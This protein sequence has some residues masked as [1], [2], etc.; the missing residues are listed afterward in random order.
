MVIRSG[1]RLRPWDQ[2]LTSTSK[3]VA[4]LSTGAAAATG[5]LTAGRP[6]VAVLIATVPVAV[7][8]VLSP[9][10]LATVLLA[11]TPF[12]IDISRGA[13]GLHAG[14]SDLLLLLAV[15]NV[16]GIALTRHGDH[17]ARAWAALRPALAWFAIYAAG[18]A[19]VLASDPSLHSGISV[20]QR[21]QLTLLPVAI[22]VTMFK[23]PAQ[24]DRALKAYLV[25]CCLL[26]VAF[27]AGSFGSTNSSILGVQKNPAGQ[28]MANALVLAIAL[29]Q[30]R[31][32]RVVAIPV[33]GL[34]MVAAASRG[35]FV[36]LAIGVALL[37]V[38]GGQVSRRR[39]LA[40][41]TVLGVLLVIVFTGL[42]GAARSRLLN[43]DSK[44]DFSIQT[45]DRYQIDALKII[46]DHP[47]TG[48]G[49]GNYLAGDVADLSET[50]DPHN[51]ILLELAEG[52][53]LLFIPFVLLMTGPLVLVIRRRRASPYAGVAAAVHV[54]VLAHGLV[55]TYWVRSTPVLGWFLIGAALAAPAS[56]SKVFDEDAPPPLLQ[57]GH[58]GPILS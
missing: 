40:V 10:L 6:L 42:P 53:V 30:F 37:L 49:V 5:Y 28:F 46:R 25:G 45:R 26:A 21:L 27:A 4:G 2:T 51:V 54:A 34:G 23:K 52:G 17:M 29:P 9:V 16:V 41:G 36:G 48:V 8:L 13:G 7:F 56:S 19:V 31:S 39:V 15:L 1:L 22:A 24:I 44:S 32:W 12:P 50:S 57:K 3:S 58:G 43:T 14:P 55:D 47:L 38:L 35:A 18:L 11:V 33:L 20:F